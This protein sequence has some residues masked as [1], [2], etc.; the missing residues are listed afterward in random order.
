MRNLAYLLLALCSLISTSCN[1]QANGEK[2][3]EALIETT[4]GNIRVKLYNDTP[5]H[6]D[7]F[8]KNAKDG[9]YDGVLFHRIV[10]NFMIQT[11][12]PDTKQGAIV[13][14]T[15]ETERIPAEIHFPQH[16]SRKGVLAAA[17][18]NDD[19]NPERASDKYQFYI[20]TGKPISDADLDGYEASRQQKL[21]EEI[22]NQ[23]VKDNEEK[24]Q[25]MRAARQRDDLGY[26]LQD[27]MNDANYEA[28]VN[29]PLTYTN[30]IRKAYRTYGGAPWLDDDYTIFGEV[31]DGMKVVLTIQK[32]RTNSNDFPLKEI[33]INKV[34]IL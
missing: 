33:R 25:A 20:V 4:E 23:K 3:I 24:I 7:N 5:G 18:D 11:G 21:A 30:K 16:F 14:T 17:R 32:I 13:D 1:G 8:I 26:F 27:L 31:V 6:R 28:S 2:E 19:I 34:T 29:P 15:K 10:R 12:N 22:Y 9:K